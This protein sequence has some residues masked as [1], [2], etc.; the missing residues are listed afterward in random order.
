MHWW[1]LWKVNLGQYNRHER[2]K[3]THQIC[4]LGVCTCPTA[5]DQ[6]FMVG[7]DEYL[8]YRPSCAKTFVS[9]SLLSL[10]GTPAWPLSVCLI[11][12]YSAWQ[13]MLWLGPYMPIWYILYDLALCIVQLGTVHYLWP[14]GKTICRVCGK[15]PFIVYGGGWRFAGGKGT[16]HYSCGKWFTGKG[17]GNQ[18]FTIYDCG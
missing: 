16:F 11:V 2:Q 10:E 6:W 15:G 17:K 4:L 12:P 9:C 18:T 7:V 14:V 1:N 3:Q 13:P 8:Y 5:A